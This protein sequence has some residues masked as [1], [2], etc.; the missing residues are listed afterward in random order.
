MDDFHAN[1][2]GAG[3]EQW[4]T[5]DFV[6]VCVFTSS[7]RAD[8]PCDEEPRVSSCFFLPCVE[9]GEEEEDEEE[10]EGGRLGKLIQG[11]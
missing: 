3:E 9:V 10:E 7:V 2:E 1:A 11:E 4:Q 6:S 8:L 5:L